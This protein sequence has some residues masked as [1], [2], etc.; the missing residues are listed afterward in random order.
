M[1]VLSRSRN[2]PGILALR[3]SIRET[4]CLIRRRFQLARRSAAA[5]TM[6]AAGWGARSGAAL[7]EQ[8][9]ANPKPVPQIDYWLQR[10]SGPIGVVVLTISICVVSSHWLYPSVRS[11]F[12]ATVGVVLEYV[13]VSAAGIGLTFLVITNCTDPGTVRRDDAPAALEDHENGSHRDRP[14][15]LVREVDGTDGAKISYRWCDTCMLW[16]P[17]RASHCSMAC[18]GRC[19]ERFDHHCPWVGTCVASVSTGCWDGWLVCD[20]SSR[21]LHEHI[22]L[23]AVAIY[24][25]SGPAVFSSVGYHQLPAFAEFCDNEVFCRELHCTVAADSFLCHCAGGLVTLAFDAPTTKEKLTAPRTT[26]TRNPS[27][28]PEWLTA[29]TKTIRDNCDDTYC[30][31]CH[32]RQIHPERDERAAADDF[33]LQVADEHGSF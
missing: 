10:I 16:R 20:C 8:C 25:E 7:R 11:D 5:S 2:R 32:V 21:A 29:S 15:G 18:C 13:Q 24:R 22:R 27:R 26:R 30:A 4:R 28:C 23:Q 3:G 31:P 33:E 14:R 17:P 12:D 19:Y 6:T 9:C 1:P